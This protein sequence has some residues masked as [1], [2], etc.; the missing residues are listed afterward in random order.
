MISKF[1]S[2]EEVEKRLKNY[3]DLVQITDTKQE[4]L[5][6]REVCIDHKFPLDGIL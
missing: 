3:V 1:I 2:Q 4:Q 6:E 5:D